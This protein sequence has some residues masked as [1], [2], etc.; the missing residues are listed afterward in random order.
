MTTFGL[1]RLRYFSSAS[2]GVNF[3][4]HLKS[5][6]Q[7]SALKYTR[8]WWLSCTSCCT[9]CTARPWLW[10]EFSP[11][12]VAYRTE[13]HTARSSTQTADKPLR[14]ERVLWSRTT[15]YKS[16]TRLCRCLGS[17]VGQLK[18]L[19]IGCQ[20]V[21]RLHTRCWCACSHRNCSI[22]GHSRCYC[23]RREYSRFLQS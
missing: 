9:Q 4:T 18:E 17:W 22:A 10:S 19:G 8:T 23:I 6:L 14:A 16:N 1:Q 12:R 13:R 21:Y 20:D 3:Q 15:S 7:R 5:P 11:T 2:C